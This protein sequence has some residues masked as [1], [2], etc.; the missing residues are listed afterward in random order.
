MPNH[1]VLLMFAGK[2]FQIAFSY[3]TDYE[4]KFEGSNLKATT[5]KDVRDVIINKKGSTAQKDLF[6]IE[7]ASQTNS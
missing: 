3:M 7:K 2:F 6:E 5:L 4:G 1:I